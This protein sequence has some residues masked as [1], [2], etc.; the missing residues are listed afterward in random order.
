MFSVV[1]DLKISDKK[2][3]IYC[4]SLLNELGYYEDMISLIKSDVVEEYDI[5]YEESQ[6]IGSA[7]KNALNA[8][9][10]KKSIIDSMY[11]KDTVVGEE[12]ECAELLREKLC[13]DMRAIGKITYVVIR[14]KFIPK[15]TDKQ[16][17]MYYWHLMGDIMRYCADTFNENAK[18]KLHRKSLQAYSYAIEL[19]NTLKLPPS[20]PSMLEILVNLSVLHRDMNEDLDFAIKM[21]AQTFRD[22]IRNMHLLENDEDYHKTIGILGLLKDNIHSWCEIS[23][24]QNIDVL[25]DMQAEGDDYNKFKNIMDNIH[26]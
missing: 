24:R 9:R 13:K 2:E 10:K 25:F 8:K 15:T 3:F 12:K 11:S 7:F 26:T 6:L 4:M 5:T 23:G 20:N 16:T 18:K 14:T 17:L 19:A 1:D 22:A 21:A